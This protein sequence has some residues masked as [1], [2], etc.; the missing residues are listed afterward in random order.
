MTQAGGPNAWGGY[1]DDFRLSITKALGGQLAAAPSPLEWAPSTAENLAVLDERPRVYQLYLCGEFVYVGKADKSLS[2]GLGNHLR[3]LSG[4][5]NIDVSDV[6]F[7]CLYVAEDF[8]ALA[9]GNCSSA[10]TRGWA[11]SR[12]TTTVSA[13]RTP[14]GSA[15]AP[16]WRPAVRPQGVPAGVRCAPRRVAGHVAH[17][18]RDHVRGR[19]D[20]V[21][22]ARDGITGPAR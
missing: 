14:G 8:F 20:R 11:A 4:R 17:G 22:R 1:H 9:P 18:L 7:S 21:H 19:A 6:T 10:A 16:S 3:K 13:T 2:A 5:R 15:T 12:G